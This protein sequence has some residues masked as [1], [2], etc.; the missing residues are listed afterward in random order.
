MIRKVSNPLPVLEETLECLL[1]KYQY[2]AAEGTLE[3]VIDYWKDL[4]VDRTFLR[5]CFGNVSGFRRIP[6]L[7][8]KAQRF[9]KSYTVR[10]RPGTF[11]VQSVRVDHGVRPM[12]ISLGFGDDFGGIAFSCES[13]SAHSRNTF[14]TK[15]KNEE[16]WDYRDADDNTPLDFYEPFA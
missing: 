11:V 13:I 2:V 12:R 10:A 15:R 14:A 6:G 1:I 5:V 9:R 16:E 3:L 7:W 8:A 4:G